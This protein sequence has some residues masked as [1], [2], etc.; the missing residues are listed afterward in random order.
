M[1]QTRSEQDRQ[2]SDETSSREVGFQVEHPT[3][4]IVSRITKSALEQAAEY[5]SQR[6]AAGQ[7]LQ[8]PS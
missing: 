1:G 8:S 2:A 7:L 4:R 5:G 3:D 6:C